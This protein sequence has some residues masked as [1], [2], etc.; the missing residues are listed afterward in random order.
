MTK[1]FSRHTNTDDGRLQKEDDIGDI[2]RIFRKTKST[3][4]HTPGSF[5]A[6]H[7]IQGKKQGSKRKQIGQCQYMAKQ[8]LTTLTGRSH[9]G[10]QSRAPSSKTVLTNQ[11]NTRKKTYQT[12]F[13]IHAFI[14]ARLIN[15]LQSLQPR[16][17]FKPTSIQSQLM[18]NVM[19]TDEARE[20]G[21]PC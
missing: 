17:F 19:H 6:R 3:S 10:A 4:P 15:C 13:K 9:P 14:S 21:S 5:E 7:E 16:K 18:R 2:L 8:S 20:G 11:T 1:L 12:A